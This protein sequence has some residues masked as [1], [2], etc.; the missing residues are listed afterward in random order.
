M[1]CSL[2]PSHYLNQSW[3]IINS[4]SW[5]KLQCNIK[6]NSCILIQGNA[7]QNIFWK[8]AAILSRHQCVNERCSICSQIS[9][10]FVPKCPIISMPSSNLIAD[11]RQKDETPLLEPMIVMYSGAYM[12]MRHSAS[13]IRDN[14]AGKIGLWCIYDLF[15]S[16]DAS[17]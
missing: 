17:C 15:T 7:F 11:W 2:A 6:Q 10:K 3:N 16:W 9:L 4:D 1:H 5:N 12:Y 14:I 13:M 8:M